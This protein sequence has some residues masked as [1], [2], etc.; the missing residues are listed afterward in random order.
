MDFAYFHLTND[1]FATLL[2]V[3]EVKYFGSMTVL[4]LRGNSIDDNGVLDLCDAFLSSHVNKLRVLNLSETG[5]TDKGVK[6]IVEVMNQI[7]T[8]SCVL[9]EKQVEISKEV[10]M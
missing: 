3:L 2:P 4:D 9:I 8:L 5:I 1:A 7:T 6:A 10:R